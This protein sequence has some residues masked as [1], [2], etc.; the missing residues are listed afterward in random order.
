ME[1]KIIASLHHSKQ[2]N[3]EKGEAMTSPRNKRIGLTVRTRRL[4]QH[5]DSAT[6]LIE[7][8]FSI[9]QGEEGPVPTGADVLAG[10]K[11]CSPLPNQDAAGCDKLAAKSF[12]SQPLADAV[13]PITNAALTFLMCHKSLLYDTVLLFL[14][15]I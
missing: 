3:K 4:G 11:F 12:N 2:S 1:R 8:H 5:I 14:V 6:V 7:R 13:A 15:L 10:D 9:G